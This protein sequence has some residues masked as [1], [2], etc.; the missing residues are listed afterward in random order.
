MLVQKPDHERAIAGL[1]EI[2]KR[3]GDFDAAQDLLESCAGAALLRFGANH[4]GTL[5]GLSSV[6]RVRLARG[7]YEGASLLYEDLAGRYLPTL[8]MQHSLT[9]SNLSGYASSL[10]GLGRFDEAEPFHKLVLD[11]ETALL[12]EGHPRAIAA[13]DNWASCM[14]AQRKDMYDVPMI[15]AHLKSR[16]GQSRIRSQ[17]IARGPQ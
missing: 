10:Q 13:S 5:A 6:A 9:R 4:P 16:Y 17:P 7:D 11:A 15:R 14:I 2:L 1:G 8:G 3:S 12:G